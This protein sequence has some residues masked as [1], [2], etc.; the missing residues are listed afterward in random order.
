MQD[1]KV[2]FRM[3]AESVAYLAK[4]QLE[5]G[6]QDGPMEQSDAMQRIIDEHSTIPD[7][8]AGLVE[9]CVRLSDELKRVSAMCEASG[10][11][12]REDWC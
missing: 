1:V 2:T 3:R 5:W 12:Y 10:V 9:R 11:I 4:K 6:G 7:L 8:N